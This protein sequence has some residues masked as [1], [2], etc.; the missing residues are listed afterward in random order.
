MKYAFIFLLQLF[1]VRAFSQG[2]HNIDPVTKQVSNYDA[3]YRFTRTCYYDYDLRMFK[4]PLPVNSIVGIRIDQYGT[5]RLILYIKNKVVFDIEK[6][7]KENDTYLFTLINLKEEVLTARLLVVKDVVQSFWLNN[8]RDN[9]A[10][11]FY[12]N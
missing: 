8:D 9:T 6:C 1:A 7:V 2:T 5:G 12:N 4:E 11:V 3:T 10:I